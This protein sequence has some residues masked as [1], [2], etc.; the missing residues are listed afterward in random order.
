MTPMSL[1]LYAKKSETLAAVATA[2]VVSVGNADTVSA[3]STAMTVVALLRL[4]Q[5]SASS[6]SDRTWRA[7]EGLPL[8]QLRSG[9]PTSSIGEG[10]RVCR[11]VSQYGDLQSVGM[12][13]RRVMGMSL[14]KEGLRVFR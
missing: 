3:L 10:S 5:R 14:Q 6:C 13:V 11:E 8:C 4:H 12:A 9:A 1:A 7:E 2:L